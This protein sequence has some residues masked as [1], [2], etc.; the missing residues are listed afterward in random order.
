MAYVY[1]GSPSYTAPVAPYFSDVPSNHPYY[2]EICWL[3]EQGITAG[4][5]DK[6]FRPSHQV[7]RNIAAVFLYRMAGEPHYIPPVRSYFA[8]VAPTMDFYKEISWMRDMKI[9]TG[10]ANGTF[11][12]FT[13]TLRDAMCVFFYRYN[14]VVGY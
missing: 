4:Y 5:W 8:D 1:R 11:S 6:T 7:E 9:T 13:P 14:Q 3:V 2:K 12:P 10:W